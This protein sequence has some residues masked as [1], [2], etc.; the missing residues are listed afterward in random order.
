MP[1]KRQR[2]EGGAVTSGVARNSYLLGQAGILGRAMPTTESRELF[3]REVL[4]MKSRGRIAG[5]G[6]I[7]GKTGVAGAS[8]KSKGRRGGLGTAGQ[9][10]ASRVVGAAAPRVAA[11]VVG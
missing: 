7:I 2:Y 5:N 8:R 6:G 4:Q 3:R 10:G 11:P 9:R 1:V